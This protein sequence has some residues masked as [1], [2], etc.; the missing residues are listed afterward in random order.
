[1]QTTTRLTLVS[2]LLLG[3]TVTGCSTAE[4]STVSD[5]P[6][7]GGG[8]DGPG[9]PGG[10]PSEPVKPLDATGTYAL[11]ST[12]DLATN[13]PG[14]AGTVVNTII[15]ATDDSDDPTRWIVDQLIAQLP[16]GTIK[17]VLDTG[18]LFV[19]GYLNE[20]LLDLAPD[21][22]S[23][24]LQVGHDFGSIA[25][26]FGLDETLAVTRAGDGTGYVA[27]HTVTGVHFKLD[28]QD[29]AFALANYHVANIVVDHVAVTMDATGQLAIAAHDVPLAYGQ[30]LRMGLDAA[31]IPLI[32]PSAQ[33]LGQ[34]LTHVIDCDQVGA[35][36][37]DAIQSLAGFPLGSPSTFAGACT[38]GLAAGAGY[39]YAKIDDIDGTVLQFGLTG[40]ARATDR[41]QDRTI[42]AI[43]S[44][45][46]SGTLRYAGTP[47]PLIPA[48]FFGERL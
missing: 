35:A 30:V 20:R 7:P 25:K 41:T 1:M 45:T 19:V 37:A 16:D 23:T 42:D 43:Q 14:T 39:V 29:A 40:T 5:P 3:A 4:P 44:G 47:T 31:I 46:W 24:M 10:T 12:F 15:A 9:D 22:V 21:F 17:T 26:N 28:N 27:V 32:D 11:H 36:I 6:A 33:N 2:A 34:L 48:A 38:N 18:E 13:M 8:D